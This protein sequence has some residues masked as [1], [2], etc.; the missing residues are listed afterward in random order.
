MFLRRCWF[1]AERCRTGL[2]ALVSYRRRQNTRTEVYGAPEHDWASHGADAFRY[3]ATG[4]KAK[5]A[6]D[7][8]KPLKY[9]NRGISDWKPRA[10]R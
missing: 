6:A 8:F 4:L 2:D 5:P 1:D 10:L 9:D 3:L 7:Q